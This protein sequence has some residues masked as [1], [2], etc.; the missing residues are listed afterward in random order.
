MLRLPPPRLT[1]VSLCVLLS[2][3]VA[4]SEL[5]RSLTRNFSHRDFA[6][7]GQITGATQTADGRL[8]FSSQQTL[9]EFDG[10][11]WSH[12]RIPSGFDLAVTRDPRTDRLYVSA[13]D[14]IGFFARDDRAQLTH[15]SL[16]EHLP[17]HLKPLGACHGIIAHHD[18]V[19]FAIQN[20]VLVWRDD[21]FH[22]LDLPPARA[23]SKL[24][25][26]GADL[27]LHR[28][29]IGLLRFTGSAFETVV[30]DPVIRDANAVAVFQ[31]PDSLL[32][33]AGS[34]G[35]WRWQN[36]TLERWPTAADDLLQRTQISSGTILPDGRLALG[37]LDL[38]V[39]VL[40]TD[41]RHVD[42]FSLDQGVIDPAV[43]SLFLDR[44][45]GLWIGTDG[46]I[47]RLDPNDGITIFD[48][49]NGLRQPIINGI[50]RHDGRLYVSTLDGLLRLVPANPPSGRA[51]R[52]EKVEGVPRN[53]REMASHSTGLLIGTPA[54][55]LRLDDSDRTE[56]VLPLD[57]LA[58]HPIWSQHAPDTLLLG[59]RNGLVIA[60]WH[61]NR[62]EIAARF[63]GL[64]EA[65]TIAETADGTLWLGTPNR[66]FHRVRRAPGAPWT[67][68]VVTSYNE[69]ENRL[70][71][72]GWV[73][74]FP[75]P[76]G[77]LFAS[78]L[79]LLR[80]DETSDAFVPDHRL[81]IDGQRFGSVRP[82]FAAG[83]GDLW[84]QATNDFSVTQRPL[85]R[86]RPLADGTYEWRDAPRR[87]WDVIGLSGAQ[88]LYWESNDADGILWVKGIDSLL[89]LDLSQLRTGQPEWQVLLK[90]VQ[91]HGGSESIGDGARLPRLPW[92]PDPIRIT[93]TSP[94][95]DYGADL[96]YQTRL[97]GFSDDWSEPSARE[98]ATFTNLSGGPFTFEVRATD[99]EGN[100]SA[101]ARVT[102]SVTP[103]LHR[104]LPALLAYAL[105]ALGAVA[106]F[107]RWRL[108]RAA[109]EQ[110]RLEQ[111]VTQRTVQLEAANNAK[112]VFLA[113]MSHELRTPLN[114]VIGYAQVLQKSPDVVPRDRER[115]RI[116]QTSGEHL[117]RMI[118]EVLDFSKIEAG[119]LELR[120]APFHLPQLL[121]DI[122]SALEPRA[123]QK[124][125]SF[126]FNA[127]PDLPTTIIG[128][129]Q[130]LRQVLD[131]LLSNAVK[132][133]PSGQIA[134][135]VT[136]ASSLNSQPSTLN[137]RLHFSIHDTGVGISAQDQL[138]LFQP[139]H[140]PD[141]GRP[142]EPGTG[143]GLAIAK[144]L[145]ELMGG[146]LEVEST[147]G[148]GSTFSFSIPLEIV[149]TDAAPPKPAPRAPIGYR[150]DRRRL[151]VVDDVPTNRSVLVE[152]LSPLGFELRE[153]ASG[154]E[155]LAIVPAFAPHLI[156]LDLR[157]PDMNG[158]ELA[159]R[160]RALPTASHQPP[161]LIAMSASV[162][163]FN[164][165]KALE[166]GCD[167]FLPK[168]FRE[169][170]LTAKL[171]L[172]LRLEWRYGDTTHPFASRD[173]ASTASA[174]E[175]RSLLEIARRGEIRPLREHLAILRQRHPSDRH[176][177]E[178]ETFARD[179]QMERLREKL[180]ALTNDPN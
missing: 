60:E 44:D 39:L 94:R 40:S 42:Q 150:G 38:G 167:D 147:L 152:L 55:L 43:R 117:L 120:P 54:G 36:N 63:E 180:S 102:F 123:A 107:V 27:F 127:A 8:Y 80:H 163:F 50:W 71:D 164:R 177:Q 53:A 116:V 119:K 139:F 111:L 78:S 153:A 156:F 11:T 28:P 21:R 15:H 67:D 122:A 130:K 136:R 141:D 155:A 83:N 134:L 106:G 171:A 13:H 75:S 115:L 85:G 161:K 173:S 135:H 45:A 151:L 128:D 48:R 170:D 24:L 100:T 9:L 160:L 66:G 81:L 129:A 112:S 82:I 57:Q 35:F 19:F 23:R 101:P 91:H 92:S 56:L 114:G 104:S 121:R 3:P 110:Q 125:L 140:Q 86:F 145:V 172:H 4:A 98:E 157:M 26:S 176:L 148:A 16:V 108:S 20:H 96:R 133:T 10:S 59:V 169:T 73:E 6:A 76:I 37:T 105:T 142:P 103:P 64:G 132:F 87:L 22:I 30:S 165:D 1:A 69:Q 90:H 34:A 14:Q 68:A 178:L 84:A 126:T 175:L 79:G 58:L 25:Q 62:F 118:N 154:P 65:R 109:R 29:G 137:S 77:P 93:Y 143:L 162:L 61:N 7:P 72:H 95:F 2:L 149:P 46:G 131:N 174:D 49:H 17:A 88:V 89:R 113:N 52:F 99:A 32:L 159:A 70:R 144:R 97:L 146:S 74:V 31:Q 138:A 166:A 179:Y 124:N 5:G 168:P 12:H 33:A 158:F 41:G 47:T 51:A 18:A